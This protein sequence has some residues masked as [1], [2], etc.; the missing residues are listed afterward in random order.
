MDVGRLA[1]SSNDSSD[2]GMNGAVV[3]AAVPQPLTATPALKHI[4]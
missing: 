3:A 2:H 4:L 1:A